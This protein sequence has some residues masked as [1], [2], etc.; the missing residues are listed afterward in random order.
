MPQ[1]RASWEGPPLATDVREYYLGHKVQAQIAGGIGVAPTFTKIAAGHERATTLQHFAICFSAPLPDGTQFVTKWRNGFAM[2][3]AQI[4]ER[5]AYDPADYFRSSGFVDELRVSSTVRYTADFQPP[6]R[7]V[8]DVDTLALYHCDEG[9]GNVLID[10]S[11]RNNHGRL[12]NAKWALS[13]K[14][15]MWVAQPVTPSPASAPPV[16]SPPPAEEKPRPGD[17]LYIYVDPFDV[18]EPVIDVDAIRYDGSTPLT[19]EAWI[20]G[21]P[22]TQLQTYLDTHPGRT[23]AASFF[24]LGGGDSPFAKVC[25]DFMGSGD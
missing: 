24:E 18:K 23:A 14:F 7:F 8:S 16:F 20:V 9:S 3:A 10:A 15:P 13:S 5:I 25:W 1:A 21:E 11:G 2:G 22:T 12:R 17:D 19:I 6:R 4:S